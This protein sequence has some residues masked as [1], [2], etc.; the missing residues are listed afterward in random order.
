MAAAEGVR[1]CLEDDPH[2]ADPSWRPREADRANVPHEADRATPDEGRSRRS[3]PSSAS[4]TAVAPVVALRALADASV[5]DGPELLALVGVLD[6][7]IVEGTECTT[8]L[9]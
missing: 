5:A 8:A 7:H 2:E 4:S 6:V 3:T 1:S 9:G